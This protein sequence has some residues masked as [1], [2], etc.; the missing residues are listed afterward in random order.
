MGPYGS[1]DRRDNITR[2]SEGSL[3]RLRLWERE[4]PVH[5]RKAQQ[6]PR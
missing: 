4:E 1:N 3:L 2:P 6:H 5:G